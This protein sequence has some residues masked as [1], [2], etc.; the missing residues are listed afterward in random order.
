MLQVYITL[1]A[2]LMAGVAFGASGGHP[3]AVKN[4]FDKKGA[5]NLAA[6]GFTGGWLIKQQ[7]AWEKFKKESWPCPPNVNQCPPSFICAKPQFQNYSKNC[8]PFAAK[9]WIEERNAQIREDVAQLGTVR[10]EPVLDL[11]LTESVGDNKDKAYE[12]DV[13]L[14]LKAFAQQGW[15]IPGGLERLKLPFL[16]A[17]M[18]EPLASVPKGI[19][20]SVTAAQVEKEALD[21]VLAKGKVEELTLGVPFPMEKGKFIEDAVA[22]TQALLRGMKVHTLDFRGGFMS[23]ISKA[24]LPKLL[25]ALATE[26]TQVQVLDLSKLNGEAFDEFI[27]VDFSQITPTYVKKVLIGRASPS[28]FSSRAVN[29]AKEA[30]QKAGKKMK[31]VKPSSQPLS[32]S[33]VRNPETSGGYA[34]MPDGVGT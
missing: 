9:K 10:A 26:G 31:L 24:A 20:L 22:H 7:M 18:V 25:E 19:T 3:S 8:L 12:E 13:V 15:K 6:G 14:L 2:F 28:N 17:S 33:E 30:M 5:G 27:G 4:P 21:S 16:K 32:P 34:E 29:K 23:P 11:T 1:G